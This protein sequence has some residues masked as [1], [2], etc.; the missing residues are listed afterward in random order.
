MSMVR[1]LL[2]RLV[3]WI[4][5]DPGASLA[6]LASLV[7]LV[8]TAPLFGVTMNRAGDDLYHLANEIQVAMAIKRGQNPFGPLDI[9][10]GTPILK[11]YQPLFYLITGSLHALFG[12]NIVF[13]HNALTVLA[14]AASPLALHWSY[15]QIGLSSLASGLAALLTLASVAAFGNSYEAYFQAGI[16]TQSLGAVFFPLFIGAFAQLLKGKRGPVS[17][18]AL[19]GLAFVSHAIMAVYAVLSGAL[20]FLVGDFRLRR[21]FWK[22]ASFSILC[23]VLV[24]FWLVPFIQHQERHRP[25]PDLVARNGTTIWFTGL[26]PSQLDQQLFSGRLLDDAKVLHSGHQGPADALTDRLNI[27]GTLT[28]RMPFVTILV[29][30]GFFLALL[31]LHDFAHRFLVS[32]FVFSLIMLLGP[33][34]VGWLYWIPFADRIQVFRAV[35]LVE[36][37]A[38]G[39]AGAGLKIV[40]DGLRRF[41]QDHEFLTGKKKKVFFSAAAVSGLAFLFYQVGKLVYVHVDL[42]D[43]SAYEK[44]YD[45]AKYARAGFPLRVYDYYKRSDKRRNAYMSYKGMRSVCGHWGGV[46]PLVTM[47]V[48]TYLQSPLKSLTLARHLGI[49]YYLVGY[50]QD[51]LLRTGMKESK[52]PFVRLAYGRGHYLFKDTRAHYL[53]AASRPILVIANNAQWFYLNRS[54]IQS[55]AASNDRLQPATFVRLPAGVKLSPNTFSGFEEALILD[56]TRISK[57]EKKLLARISS[58]NEM[59]IYSVTPI[60][61]IKTKPIP[62]SR[63]SLTGSS[64]GPVGE[65]P[66]FRKIS[67]RLGGPITYEVTMNKP[68]VVVLPEI[69][70]DGWQSS[71]DGSK[72]TVLEAGPDFVSAVVP[73]GRHVLCFRWRTPRREELLDLLSIMGWLGVIT[74]FIVKKTGKDRA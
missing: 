73:K 66:K 35:Y 65:Q 11:F 13:L 55:M 56:P 28:L 68:G 24:A 51:K 64:M 48:C 22:L 44:L 8:T 16:V 54:W 5:N 39:L 6:W 27:M 32:G 23:F 38:F 62:T 43:M 58:S 61:G 57:H 15:R 2:S 9:I 45:V 72:T 63:K 37:F 41:F 59:A 50:H 21:L 4:R 70:V 71:L 33:D 10:F 29:L 47:Q 53:W 20:M 12:F 69:A 30:L 52:K 18:S 49:G 34:D 42:R 14:F 40:F 3:K 26:S 1:L 19:F 74:W 17:T 7:V 36:F 25:V 60:K 46:G 31:H 67:A